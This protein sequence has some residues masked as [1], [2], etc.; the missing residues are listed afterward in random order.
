MKKMVHKFSITKAHTTLI[1]QRVTPNHDIM[2]CK[3]LTMSCCP[4]KENHFFR[5]L[6]FP[7]TLPREKRA[8]SIPDLMVEG[9][10]IYLT[11]TFE[12]PT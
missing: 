3:N 10:S 4:Q 1:C 5:N 12:A 11:I 6:C 7:N 2:Q 8:R 9:P